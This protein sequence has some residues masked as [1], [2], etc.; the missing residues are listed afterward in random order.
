MPHCMVP[1]CTNGSKKT[2]G[3][4]ISY[5]RLPKDAKLKKIWISKTSRLNPGKENSCY[6]CSSH[7]TQDC[8]EVSY[9]HLCGQKSKKVL[10]PGSIP[11]IFPHTR[12]KLERYKTIQRLCKRDKT[13]VNHIYFYFS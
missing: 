13:K 8:F 12:Q 7:F 3:T 2:K 11:T 9:K 5:H 10:K 6:V 4:E 1:G